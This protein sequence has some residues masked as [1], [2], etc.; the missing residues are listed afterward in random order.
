MLTD[1][2]CN[3]RKHSV[4]KV[5]PSCATTRAIE[6]RV[7]S[8]MRLRNRKSK[9]WQHCRKTRM[10]LIDNR[11][12][13]KPDKFGS[14]DEGFLRWKIRTESFILSVFPGLEE[15]LTWA[16]EHEASI[17][18]VDV[19][20]EFGSATVSPVEVAGRRSLHDRAQLPKG[21]WVRSLEKNQQTL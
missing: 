12:V 5:E 18:K 21:Q 19:E 7:K 8:W 3:S 10:T 14:K 17:G 2:G 4:G 15:P 9:S 20:A 1:F 11:G 6:N 13:A 16:E